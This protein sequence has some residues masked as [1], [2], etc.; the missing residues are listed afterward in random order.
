[1]KK[2][3]LYLIIFILILFVLPVLCTKTSKE[4]ALADS[5]ENIEA[6]KDKETKKEFKQYDYSKCNTIKLYHTKTK[7]IEEV[8]L[9]EYLYNTISAEMPANYEIEALKAQAVASRTYTLYQIING[10]SK[11]GK[12]DI[13]D[14]STCCQAWI[15]KEDRFAKWKESD[16]ESNWNKITE[17]VNSTSG[18]VIT[19]KNKLIDAF[20]HAN[21]GGKTE[22]VSDVWGGSN[23][24]Y[25]QSVETSGESDYSGYSSN[26]NISQ[27]DLLNKLKKDHKDVKIDFKKK[28]EI[29]I[30]DYTQG[31]RVKTVKFGNIEIAGTEVRKILGLRSTNFKIKFDKD[32]II[33]DVVGYGHGVGMS[34]TGANSMAKS[35]KNFEAIIK[36][37]YT[38]VEIKYLNDL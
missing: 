9:D 2:L 11:H 1:M 35:G 28:D 27:K 3:Y 22:N 6:Q 10:G 34:Q 7:K 4:S 26:V 19:Y 17:A 14:D 23:Y 15:S 32:N 36:H 24:P 12:A 20:F 37:F 33:F 21:S 16:R 8:G 25:L 31:G 13:C 30:L 29:K 18:K 38:G 5:G